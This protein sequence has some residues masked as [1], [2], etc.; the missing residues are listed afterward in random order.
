MIFSVITPSFNCQNFILQNLES[1]RAQGFDSDQLEHLIVDGGST[2]GTVELLRAASGIKWSSEPD[3]GLSDAVNKGILRSKADWIIWLN[4]DDMLSP[5]A[6]K[7]FLEYAARYSDVRIFSG[8]QIILRYDGTVEQTV[9]GWDYNL[10]DLLGYRTGIN[11]AATFVHRSVYE[12]VGLLDVS[13]KYAMDYE[14]LVRAMHHY[15]CVPIPHVLAYYRRRPGSI[16]DANQV[17]QFQ[18]FL[19][20][21]RIYGKSHFSLGELR[22][23]F[24]I[25]TDPLRRIRWIRREV[26]RIKR[27]LGQNPPH[28]Y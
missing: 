20:I 10:D 23:R 4:A 28:P 12:K 16:T 13:N 21:R 2:D 18:E 22:S 27:W 5:D 11:Q 24:Y 26:R 17:K 1:V 14:W 19:R 15:R 8:D 25:Y 3:K 9:P 6:C 7:V